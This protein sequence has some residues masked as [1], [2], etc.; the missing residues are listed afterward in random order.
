MARKKQSTVS[1]IR[2]LGLSNQLC[3]GLKRMQPGTEVAVST[4]Y[5]MHQHVQLAISPPGQLKR[6][7]FAVRL[8]FE[9]AGKQYIL[10]TYPPDMYEAV[11]IE[12]KVILEAKS[13]RSLITLSEDELS[14]VATNC[15]PLLDADATL[16]IEAL[17]RVFGPIPQWQA[18]TEQ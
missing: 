5:L 9:H 11:E 6:Y 10:I 13:S 17:S 1:S 14:V 15:I 2:Q 8:V 3:L 4:C 16:D 7:W 12:P 18:E